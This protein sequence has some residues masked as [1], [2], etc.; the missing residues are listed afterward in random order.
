MAP[1]VARRSYTA[2]PQIASSRNLGW[3]LAIGAGLLVASLSQNNEAEA[4]GIPLHGVPGTDKERTFIA[5]KPD[6]VQRGLVGDIVGRFEKRGYKLV[7]LKLVWPTK[8]FAAEH[9]DDLKTKPFF[10]GLVSYFSSGPVVAMVWQGPNAIKGGRKLLGATR[11][12]DSEPGT[13]RGDLCI[14]VGR[15]ICHGSDSP[16]GAQHEIN[17]WF[18]EKEMHDWNDCKESWILGK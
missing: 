3:G 4:A 14:T 16:E 7:A 13:I 1:V 5:I 8:E 6:G 9:Y 12:D 10:N 2:A 11:P 17:H 15:N 18:T